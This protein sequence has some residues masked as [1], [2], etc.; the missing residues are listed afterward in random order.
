M[1][2]KAL[3]AGIEYPVAPMI[4]RQVSLTTYK[5]LT[6][7]TPQKFVYCH[8][9]LVLSCHNSFKIKMEQAEGAQVHHK[10]RPDGAQMHIRLPEQIPSRAGVDLC[11]PRH[12]ISEG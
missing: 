7:R 1:V 3:C 10:F 2:T 12:V 5:L 11:R 6:P 4:D 8:H 9:S